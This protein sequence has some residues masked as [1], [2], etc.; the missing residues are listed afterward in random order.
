[1]EDKIVSQFLQQ[2]KFLA[3]ELAASG[4]QLTSSDFHAIIY[5]ALGHECHHII[6]ALF[7]QGKS[8]SF[9]ELDGHLVSHEILLNATKA[10]MPPANVATTGQ[11]SNSSN[12]QLHGNSSTSNT[13]FYNNNGRR[14]N[15]SY[16]HGNKNNRDNSN[17]CNN[18]NNQRAPCQICNMTNHSAATCRKR[19]E[20]SRPNFYGQ[21]QI[22]HNSSPLLPTPPSANYSGLGTQP[23]VNI[24]IYEPLTWHPDTVATNNITSDLTNLQI[25]DEYYGSDKLIIGNGVGLNIA[26]TGASTLH[27]QNRIFTLR[28][29][30][31]VLNIAKQLLSVQQF[32]IDNNVYFE[33]HGRYFVMKDEVN[34]QL[35]LQGTAEDRIYKFQGTLKPFPQAFVAAKDNYEQWHT[36]LGHPAFSIVKQVLHSLNL[37]R[38]NPAFNKFSSCLLGINQLDFHFLVLVI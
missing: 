37:S 16:N 7:V 30:L 3:D 35:L 36:R 14:N 6:S 15:N 11:N 32:A 29:I 33:F 2:A 19:Y 24:S 9:Y 10:K 34:K 22:S 21:R 25:V 27:S 8:V 18:N 1:M 23:S 4:H 20:P 5:R 17:R 38:S 13:R 26:H 12:N 28:N 31:H